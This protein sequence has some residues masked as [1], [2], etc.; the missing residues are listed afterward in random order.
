MRVGLDIDDVLF[1]WTEHAHA[2]AERAGI[3][4]G[5]QI[6]QWDF[7]ADYGCTR[8]EWWDVINAE[9]RAGMLEREPYPGTAN[10]LAL[11][12][13]NGAT[14]HLVTARGF[15]GQL[16]GF[17]RR[18]TAEWATQL[19]HDSL[20]FSKDKAAVRTEVFLDDS[21]HNC[22]AVK[23]VGTFAFLRDQVHNRGMESARLPRARDLA[24]FLC[25]VGAISHD[26]FA[27]F[28]QAT[29]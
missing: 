8:E 26:Q 15:E 21:V 23:K 28:R 12:R 11:A 27:E 5:A 10:L 4:N 9:Y 20:T 29:R 2:A 16:A 13:E 14:I 6:T 17:V 1:P 24:Q 19:P 25:L 3:T 22:L 18:T 7:A